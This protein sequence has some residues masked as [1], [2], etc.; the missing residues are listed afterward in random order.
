M[1]TAQTHHHL[2]DLAPQDG[3]LVA[4][5]MGAGIGNDRSADLPAAAALNSADR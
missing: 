3:G 4:A 1:G 2:I 5:V